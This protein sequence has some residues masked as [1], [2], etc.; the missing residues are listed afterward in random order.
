MLPPN[1]HI[2]TASMADIDAMA[3]LETAAHI[4]PWSPQSLSQVV[5][6]Q[7]EACGAYLVRLLQSSAGQH[8]TLYGYCIALLGFQE[9][10][11]LNLAVA[12]QHQRKGYAHILLRDLCACA[13]RYGA[14]TIW[15]EVRQSNTRAQAMYR[16][17]GFIDVGMRADYYPAPNGAREAA[18]VMQYNMQK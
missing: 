14:Y 18:C 5:Q 16:R 8:K 11:L 15:L 1:S 13:S 10:H 7:G 2:T 17:F 4:A 6:Q 3:Q 9:L 12:P